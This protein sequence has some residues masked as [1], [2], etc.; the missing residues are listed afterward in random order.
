MDAAAKVQCPD[1][2]LL[3]LLR[4]VEDCFNY[5]PSTHY[6][7]RHGVQRTTYE[8]VRYV[9]QRLAFEEAR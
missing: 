9:E 6:R 7:N 4:E 3:E 2:T 5:L 1:L 8:L